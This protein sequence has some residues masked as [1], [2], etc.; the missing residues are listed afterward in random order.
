MDDLLI[1]RLVNRL[2]NLGL[3]G[4]EFIQQLY[5]NKTLMSGSFLLGSIL[6]EQY[7]RCD[8]DLYCNLPLYDKYPSFGQWIS[9]NLKL[10]CKPSIEKSAVYNEITH[11]M[12]SV[13]YLCNGIT[14]QIMIISDDVN[15]KQ[16][17]M[18]YFD[19]SF[20]KVTFDGISLTYNNEVFNKIGHINP[21][22]L[23][24]SYFGNHYH[25]RIVKY[26]NRGFVITNKDD[27]ISCSITSRSS[28][29]LYYE[30][31]NKKEQEYKIYKGK[32]NKLVERENTKI[33]NI[34]T[35]RLLS[36][37]NS[38]PVL[39]CEIRQY[40][41]YLSKI[42]LNEKCKY[43]PKLKYDVKRYLAVARCFK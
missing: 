13:T 25:D 16:L 10:F 7:D 41:I 31:L 2:D 28:V 42:I 36:L 11:V 24:N 21:I 32:R 12:K 22:Y 1:K 34:L 35:Y 26:E 33:I 3:K 15:P 30:F 38:S 9:K 43:Y 8:I 18:D 37:D 23:N 29:A 19:L 40:I 4:E 6:D 14:I 5:N 20:C 27:L 17:I 39:P